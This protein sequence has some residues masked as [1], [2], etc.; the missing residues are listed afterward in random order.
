VRSMQEGCGQYSPY[1]LEN[2][3]FRTKS[4][5]QIYEMQ[6]DV[7]SFVVEAQPF[8]CSR[9]RLAWW[10][11]NDREKLFR[12]DAQVV[13]QN[14]SRQLSRVVWVEFRG[15]FWIEAVK[16]SFDS[17]ASGPVELIQ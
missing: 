12:L 7:T 10:P 16:I 1:V 4:A 15:A 9:E 5:N 8:A 6:E 13:S 14:G 2:C 11:S 3:V 17:S